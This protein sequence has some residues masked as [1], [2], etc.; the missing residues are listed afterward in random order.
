MNILKY[1]KDLFKLL[2]LLRETRTHTKQMHYITEEE[3]EQLEKENPKLYN[4][5]LD[6]VEEI[7]DLCKVLF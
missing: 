1:E 7:E 5:L 3:A 6:A 2:D 4:K